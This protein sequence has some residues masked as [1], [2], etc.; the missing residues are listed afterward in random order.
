MNT[1]DIKTRAYHITYFP[2]AQVACLYFYGCNF[3]CRGCIRRRCNFDIHLPPSEQNSPD[4]RKKA[5]LAQ[6]Q[7]LSA[8]SKEKVKKLIF[9][10]GEPTI[11]LNLAF[12]AGELKEKLNTH[13]ALLTN[14]YI[15]PDVS[16]FNEVCVGI[17]AKSP[18]L[19]RDYTGKG[20]ERVFAN[21]K[22]FA[23]SGVSL[24]AECVFIPEYIGAKEIGRIARA[25]SRTD[26]DIPLRIDAYIPVPGEKW[27]RPQKKEMKEVVDQAKKY[28]KEVS[29]LDGKS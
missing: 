4:R 25:L 24:R 8:L 23:K 10:G 6:S 16:F 12:L 19:H 21:I 28:L 29:F 11:D 14:G 22:K 18:R 15:M 3:R 2:K 7:I 9:M 26:A 20:S 13:N 17:K 5:F 27:R 1:K